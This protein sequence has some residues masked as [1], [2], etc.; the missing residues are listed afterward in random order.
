[1]SFVITILIIGLLFIAITKEDKTSIVILAIL[2]LFLLMVGIMQREKIQR[3]EIELNNTEQ[4]RDCCYT[5]EI[6][7]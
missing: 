5:A 6:G 1:M 7:K 2:A 4:Q 3:L